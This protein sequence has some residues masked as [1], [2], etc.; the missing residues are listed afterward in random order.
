[1]QLPQNSGVSSPI[2]PDLRKPKA[3][4][5][6]RGIPLTL[7]ATMPKAS[8]HKNCQFSLWEKEVR[9]A[10]KFL[11]MFLPTGNC[12]VLKSPFDHHFGGAISSTSN[13]CH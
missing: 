1:M 10:N 4:A 3:P 6:M 9:C 12:K 2:L 8:I 7:L 5:A 11:R 13:F